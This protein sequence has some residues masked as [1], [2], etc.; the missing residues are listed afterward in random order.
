MVVHLEHVV[1]KED[2][3]DRLVRVRYKHAV[4]SVKDRPGAMDP[5]TRNMLAVMDVLESHRLR[6]LKIDTNYDY[7]NNMYT[8]VC[9]VTKEKKKK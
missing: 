1:S 8:H 4:V 3:K 2:N 5:K 9:W 7:N 6:C